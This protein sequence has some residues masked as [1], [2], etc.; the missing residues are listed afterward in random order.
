MA[1]SYLTKDSMVR[2]PQVFG[3][4]SGSAVLTT[5]TNEPKKDWTLM[6]LLTAGDLTVTFKDDSTLTILALEAGVD[7]GIHDVTFISFDGTILV[8]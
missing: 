8:S 7:F 2:A 4:R 3:L 5:T 1:E 6:K